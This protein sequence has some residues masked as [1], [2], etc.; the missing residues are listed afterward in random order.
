MMKN[1]KHFIPLSP[2]KA[3]QIAK[4]YSNLVLMFQYSLILFLLIFWFIILFQD[5][6]ED[7]I[8]KFLYTG[9][10][11]NIARVYVA[12]HRILDLHNRNLH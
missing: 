7:K 5:A 6:I 12:G 11:R 4:E 8:Q 2:Q 9:D 10:D 1:M 3:Y